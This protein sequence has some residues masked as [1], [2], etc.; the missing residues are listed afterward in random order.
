LNP[1]D[2]QQ[3]GRGEVEKI[4]GFKSIALKKKRER[5]KGGVGYNQGIKTRKTKVPGLSTTEEGKGGGG[6]GE[7]RTNPPNVILDAPGKRTNKSQTKQ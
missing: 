6:L 5:R 1:G 4:M 7:R 3:G 2:D